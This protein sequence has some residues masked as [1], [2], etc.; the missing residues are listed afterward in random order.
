MIVVVGLGNIGG[1]IAHRLVDCGQQVVAV[2]IDE[3]RCQQ[4]RADTGM[5]AVHTLS[6]VDWT[7]IE[8]VVVLVRLT[9][10]VDSVLAELAA[11][12]H[13]D[14]L[15]VYIMSTLELAFA[16]GLGDLAVEGVRVVETPVSGGQK[17]AREGT[18][19]MMIAGDGAD[20]ETFLLSTLASHVVHFAGYGEP[21]L[22]KLFNNVMCA[23]NALSMAE[24]LVLADQQGVDAGRLRDVLLTSSGGSWVT[25]G[26]VDLVDDLLVKDV[27]LFE[28]SVGT[29]P[30]LE[31]GAGG[32]L[33]ARLVLARR[34]LTA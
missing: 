24:M 18:L 16:R 4:W 30:P 20:D 19:T 10:Q 3:D 9:E 15:A 27:A 11:I 2:E 28:H 33:E 31:I 32:D 25:G 14:G 13:I 8:R 26:F 7:T 23:Y 6:D 17:A 1:A 5:T 34:L 21:T 22:V 29:L 12:D